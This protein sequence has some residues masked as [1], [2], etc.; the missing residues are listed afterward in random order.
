MRDL[1]ALTARPGVLSL[2][3]GL[4]AEECLPHEQLQACIEAVLTRDGGRALQ[5]GPPYPPLKDHIAIY[6]RSR[7]VACT[8]EDIFITGGSQQGLEIVMRSLLDPGQTALVEEYTFTG[9]VQA[10]Q[11]RGARILALPVDLESGL[12]LDAFESALARRPRVAAIIPDFHNPLGVSLP[13]SKRMRLA[14]LAARQGL[15][16]VEDDPYSPLRFEGKLLPP[17]KAFDEAEAVI[18]LG[19]FSK[20]LAPAL[21]LGWMVAARGLLPKF[22]V[23]RESLDLES[24]QLIQRA[25][26]EFL[27]RG[28]LERHLARLNAVNRERRDVMLAALDRELG[29]LARWTA[30]QGGLFVWVTLPGIDVDELFTAALELD[31]AFVPGRAFAAA[32]GQRTHGLRLNFSNAAPEIIETAIGRLAAAVKEQLTLPAPA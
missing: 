1:L 10:T 5:Y 18:Y 24:S 4:P 11:G 22:T 28:Y 6:M 7:G 3:G 29:G 12:D 31:L 30:P 21:R 23:V 20:M 13:E 32:A 8:A 17:V 19:S 25:V 27:A 2:A 15:P 14:D 26:A 16:I 9:I